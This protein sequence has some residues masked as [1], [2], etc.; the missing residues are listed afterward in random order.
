MKIIL[1]GAQGSG[2][3]TQAEL[4]AKKFNIPAI[5]T[6]VIYRQEIARKTKLG[7]IAVEYLNKGKLAPSNL[8]NEVMEKR[9]KKS[10]CKKGFILD[11]YPR[12]LI[13]AQFLDKISKMDYVIE[14]VLSDKECLKRFFGRQNCICGAVYHLK[15]NLPKKKGVC[16]KCGK[17][18]FIREDEK[19]EAIKKR[20]QIY[21]QE[22][23][24]LLKEYQKMGIL[25]KINGNQNIKDVYKEIISNIKI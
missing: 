6:G 8:T 12:D 20:L 10:D 1:F 13:Q 24:P 14:I 16:N 9:L 23:K 17:E 15:F 22:T 4:L 11:G 7:K 19:P 5:S 25:I 21:H 3:G 18:L 2:K